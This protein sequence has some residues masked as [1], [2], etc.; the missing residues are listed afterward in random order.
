MKTEEELAKPAPHE[1]AIRL[2]ASSRAEILEEALPI[3]AL[4]HGKESQEYRDVK[5][6]ANKLLGTH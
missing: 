3:V 4:I 2:G 5:R 6:C 1:R